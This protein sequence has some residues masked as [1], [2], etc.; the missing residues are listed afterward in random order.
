M[1]RRASR[2]NPNV[3]FGDAGQSETQLF[4]QLQPLTMPDE[5][6]AGNAIVFGRQ[7]RPAGRRDRGGR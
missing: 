6:P 7:R 4:D 5:R 3:V 1:A 2:G